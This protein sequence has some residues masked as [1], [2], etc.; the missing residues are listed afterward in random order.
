MNTILNAMGWLEHR[1]FPGFEPVES[2]EHI[3]ISW[4]FVVAVVMT[5]GGQRL[6]SP[7][8][9]MILSNGIGFANL[10]GLAVSTKIGGE[11]GFTLFRFCLAIGGIHSNSLIS[12]SMTYASM[13]PL[14][15]MTGHVSTGLGVGGL[16]VF[17]TAVV[18]KHLTS[19]PAL[20]V[21]AGFLGVYPDFYVQSMLVVALL[22]HAAGFATAIFF[23]QNQVT[24]K[25]SS[26]DPLASAAMHNAGYAAAVEEGRAEMQP[27]VQPITDKEGP[28]RMDSSSRQTFAATF[29]YGVKVLMQVLSPAACLFLTMTGTFI[30]FPAK[31]M[32]LKSNMSPETY[33]M[34]CAGA[35][36][37]GDVV[38]RQLPTDLR[39][40]MS[41]TPLAAYATVRALFFTGVFVVL[42]FANPPYLLSFDVSKL[43][44][45]LAA[46]VTSGYLITCGFV[47]GVDGVDEADMPYAAP[48]LALANIAGIW[49]GSVLYIFFRHIQW[50]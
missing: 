8:L 2:F 9:T 39:F 31:V 10:I 30:I 26:L 50:F 22:V 25:A 43:L 24:A 4:S 35:M 41:R 12:G 27:E 44:I 19:D 46:A 15:I 13:D 7:R 29:S 11:S 49:F 6:V 18:S 3:Y 20:G 32:G 45:M 38:G 34:L 47:H 37:V 16:I 14:G 5:L 28:A 33:T 17:V 23:D 1:A 48:F 21:G 42:S 40:L 36:Q